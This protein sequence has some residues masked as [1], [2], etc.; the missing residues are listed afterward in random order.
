MIKTYE[1]NQQV[2]AKEHVQEI[3]RFFDIDLSPNQDENEFGDK[4]NPA[5][6]ILCLLM[7]GLF[8]ACAMIELFQG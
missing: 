5:T 1:D 8:F 2:Q 4:V 7:L 6:G 3:E